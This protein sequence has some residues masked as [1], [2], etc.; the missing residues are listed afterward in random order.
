MNQ[1][2]SVILFTDG[3]FNT[4]IREMTIYKYLLTFALVTAGTPVINAQTDVTAKYITNPSF[5]L[6]DLDGLTAVN[7]NSDGLRGWRISDP[8]GWSL[9][10]IADPTLIVTTDCYTDNNFGKVTTLA[11]GNQAFYMRVGWV[12]GASSLSQKVTLPAG[13][14]RLTAD[15]RSA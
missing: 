15:I 9:S 13:S 12:S 6:D 2:P 11:N 4:I 3:I 14:Y 7:N 8:Q 10:G 5:E 1:I